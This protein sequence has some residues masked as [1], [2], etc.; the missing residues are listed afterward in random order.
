MAS[1]CWPQQETTSK[2]HKEVRQWERGR[3]Q[4]KKRGE[5][6]LEF[7]HVVVDAHERRST[8]PTAPNLPSWLPTTMA[9]DDPRRPNQR[10]GPTSWSQQLV[11]TDGINRIKRRKEKTPKIKGWEKDLCTS[12]IKQ[13]LSRTRL[14]EWSKLIQRY[15][16][17]RCISHERASV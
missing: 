10:T 8:Q 9:Q 11:D 14:H 3:R 13:D 16:T 5:K 2:P 15:R 1:P 7:H 6:S 4:K 12:K 17:S